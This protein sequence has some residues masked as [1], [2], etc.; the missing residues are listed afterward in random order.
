MAEILCP[1]CHEPMDSL[2]PFTT[3]DDKNKIRMFCPKCEV[4]KE[5]DKRDYNWSFE[6]PFCGRDNYD[7]RGAAYTEILTRSLGECCDDCCGPS[8][9]QT[10]LNDFDINANNRNNQRCEK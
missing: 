3:E 6:C 5:I 4:Y 10:G 7:P 9:K 1:E 8:E 2:S